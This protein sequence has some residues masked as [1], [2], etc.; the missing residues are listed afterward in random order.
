[1]PCRSARMEDAETGNLIV[2]VQDA[3][4]FDFSM[5]LEFMQTATPEEK[6]RTYD[7][8]ENFVFCMS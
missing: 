5:S 1:M 6:R 3:P 4:L 7:Y 8:Y 2:D